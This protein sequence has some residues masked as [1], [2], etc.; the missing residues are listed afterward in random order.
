[1]AL[2]QRPLLLFSFSPF[3]HQQ[4]WRM[5]AL[6]DALCA[7]SLN[8]VLTYVEQAVACQP[9]RASYSSC[10]RNAYSM[11][12]DDADSFAF[13]QRSCAAARLAGVCQMIVISAPIGL[14][15]V[16]RQNNSL[17]HSDELSLPVSLLQALHTRTLCN[18]HGVHCPTAPV[19]LPLATPA[20]TYLHPHYLPD[21]AYIPTPTTGISPPRLPC[22]P[23]DAIMTPSLTAV[24]AVCLNG[25]DV[26]PPPPDVL[27]WTFMFWWSVLPTAPFCYH[28]GTYPT[29]G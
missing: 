3:L 16:W 10:L 27:R 8:F 20:P 26:P 17:C 1:M 22:S 29:T 15:A 12:G 2:E 25:P 18:A 6:G 19:Y 28:G 14:F 11:A 5:A 23:P 13:I 7:S 24:Y 4:C 9:T 21:A